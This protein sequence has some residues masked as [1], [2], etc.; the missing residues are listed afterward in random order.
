M[1]VAVSGGPDSVALLHVLARLRG[2]LG[3]ELIAH[4]V[5]H[6]LRAEAPAELALAVELAHALGVPMGVSAVVVKRGGNLQARAREARYQALREAMDAAGATKL[7]TGHHAEDRAETVLL[8]LLQGSGPVG[9]GCL[10]AR[11]EEKIRPLLGARRADI[12][13]HLGRHEI[14]YAQDPSNHDAMY[15]RSRVR[16]E[17]MPLL[18]QLSPSIVSHLNALADDLIDRPAPPAGLGRAQRRQLTDA[19]ARGRQGVQI[20]LAGGHDAWASLASGA[21][22]ITKQRLP[23]APE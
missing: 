2:R 11:H 4:G 9:L 21:V 10:P 23:G 7:A 15:L 18:E 3:F 6:G 20:R 19:L 22:M 16:H 14:R 5:D 17:L 1:L 12:L 8:R 13:S